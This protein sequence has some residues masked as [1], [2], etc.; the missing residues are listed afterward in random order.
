MITETTVGES[1]HWLVAALTDKG[2]VA[3]TIKIFSL[4]P[5]YRRVRFTLV[6]GL[7]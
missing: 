6:C 7:G 3:S 4:H 2:I 1:L 5:A